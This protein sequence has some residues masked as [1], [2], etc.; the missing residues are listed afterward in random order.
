MTKSSQN[1]KIALPLE[2]VDSE[3]CALIVDKSLRDI[4]GLSEHKIEINNKRVLLE[5]DKPEVLS[6][7]VKTITDLGYGVPIVKKIFPVLEMTCASCAAS[8]ESI[9]NQESGVLSAVVNFAT[10]TVAVSYSPGVTSPEKLKKALQD[11]GYDLFLEKENEENDTIEALHEA[12][13]SLLKK[14]TYAAVILAIPLIIIGM[15]FMDMPYANIIMWIL[16]T[17]IV[18]GLGLDFFKNA[19]KQANHRSANMDTLVALS[20]GVAYLFSVFNTVYPQFWLERGLEPHVYFEAA[21]VVIAFIL[22]GKLLEEKAK[23]NTSTA[24]KKLMGLQP[25]KVTV[26]NAT[27]HHV[28]IPVEE[29]I[30]G[31]VILVKPGEK[32]AVD[33]EVISGQSYVDESMLSGE[34]VA[35]LKV[36]KEKVFAGTLN[37]KGSFQFKAEKIG[38]TTLLS[39]IIKMVQDAQ[40]SKAPVQKLV[41]KIASIFVPIVLGIAV[42]S[43]FIWTIFGGANGFTHGMMAL[44]TVLVI[45]CPCALGLATPTAIMVGVGKGAENGILIKDA[46]SLELAKKINVVILDKTGTITEGKP[47]VTE[48]YWTTEAILPKQILGS[49]EQ[50]SEHPL[51]DAVVNHLKLE[52]FVTFTDFESIT[53]KGVKAT[54]ENDNY[55]VGNKKLIESQLIAIDQSLMAKA[56]AWGNQA[57]TV[58]WFANSKQVLAVLAIADSI[59][60]SSKQAIAELQEKGIEVYMLTGDNPTTA[61]AVAES[62]GILH[63]QAEVMPEQKAQ[64]VKKLQA[65]GKIVA[66]VGDGINDSAALAQADVS[67]AMGHGSAI[68]M[69]AAKITLISSDLQKI[70]EAIKLSR[71]TVATIKQNLFWAFIYNLIGIPIAAGILYPI[72]GFLLN[73]MLAGAAMALSSVSVVSNSLRLKWKK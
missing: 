72:N 65:E 50:Q 7:V 57:Q 53:G 47:S 51:A 68:A 17:P 8:V 26:I 37:Q 15:F 20:T 61:K 18:F 44:V 27:G 3:H 66:M 30:I 22:L 55:F 34:P 25:K 28:E 23:G 6:T 71:N 64:F 54:Y 41:D 56:D 62:V 2:G 14:K 16:S 5:Y 48:A 39:Q 32:I 31:A 60:V 19:W 52:N 12:K 59:K 29:V 42:V 46:E 73:P 67:I 10:A 1:I 70:P 36:E 11:G 63:F 58:I 43:L 49:M 4:Q 40:G 13:F 21:G 33:G 38:S 45:A 9:L 24:I 35:V 69:D